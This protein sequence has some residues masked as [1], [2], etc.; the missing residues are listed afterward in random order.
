MYGD[1]DI[2]YWIKHDDQKHS[3][4]KYLNTRWSD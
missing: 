3:N 1:V 4:I 2:G